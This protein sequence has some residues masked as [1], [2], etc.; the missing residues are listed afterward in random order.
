M[1]VQKLTI[2][3]EFTIQLATQKVITMDS[4]PVAIEI[5]HS[6]TLHRPL[7]RL[8]QIQINRPFHLKRAPQILA[9]ELIQ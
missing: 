1:G 3:A 8:S 9:W 6:L 2:M 4:L 7:G 5:F